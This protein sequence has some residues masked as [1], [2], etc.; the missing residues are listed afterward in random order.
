MIPIPTAS[1][2]S[3]LAAQLRAEGKI[4]SLVPTMGALHVGKASLIRA[5][6]AKGD[7]VLVSIFVN[8]LQFG[9]SGPIA[10]YPRRLAEDLALCAA[11]G[12]AAVFTPEPAELFPRGFSTFV[13]EEG[14]NKTLCGPSRPTHFR[15]VATVMAQ[16]FNLTRPHR[17]FFGQKTAQRAAVVRKMAEDLRTAVETIVEPTVREPDGLAAGSANATLTPSQRAAAL[18]LSSTLR[19]VQEMADSG[20]RSP[21]RLIA[22]ATHLLGEQRRVRLIYVSIVDRQTLEPVREIIPGRQMMAMAA[23]IDEIRLIDNAVLKPDPV[24]TSGRRRPHRWTIVRHRTLQEGPK[25]ALQLRQ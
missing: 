16:L 24:P 7:A 11:C 13:T 14:L 21:D 25:I 4:V 17:V 5:A 18:S 19:R 1:Q 9:P 15:G 6:V 22:E 2:F 3:A 23:W 10:R 20:V 12:A 8:P